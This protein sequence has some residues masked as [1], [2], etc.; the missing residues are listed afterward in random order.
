MLLPIGRAEIGIRD[1]VSAVDHHPIADIKAN[2]GNTRRI[3]GADEKHK[4]TR[5][6]TA[7]AGTDVAKSLCAQSAYIPAGMIDDP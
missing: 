4:I 5:L 7:G 6:G 2:V 3:V 1:R